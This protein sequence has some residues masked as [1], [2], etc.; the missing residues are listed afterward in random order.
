MSDEQ[1][2]ATIPGVPTRPSWQERFSGKRLLERGRRLN[3]VARLALFAVALI[4]LSVMSVAI[5]WGSGNI[6]VRE[7]D[8]A[9]QTI[10]APEAASF[11]SELRTQ[12]A[13]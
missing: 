3:A 7:G 13:R 10:K 5:D 12:E 4:V 2:T 11:E 6:V 9:D 8:A 1:Q